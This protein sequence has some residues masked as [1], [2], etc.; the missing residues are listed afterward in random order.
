M[1]DPFDSAASLDLVQDGVPEVWVDVLDD[2]ALR[3]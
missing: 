3:K 2:K 1:N